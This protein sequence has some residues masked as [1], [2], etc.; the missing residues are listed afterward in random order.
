M[1]P[2]LEI[3]DHVSTNLG[4]GVIV[5]LASEKRFRICLDC[6][7]RCVKCH[8]YCCHYMPSLDEIEQATEE[9]QHGW[10]KLQEWQRTS[11]SDRKW[12]YEIPGS[13]CRPPLQE[14][15]VRNHYSNEDEDD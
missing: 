8:R 1:K 3:G 7:G 14:W 12:P 15:D 10:T 5:G 9:I 11:P 13:D 6:D 4:D 2:T